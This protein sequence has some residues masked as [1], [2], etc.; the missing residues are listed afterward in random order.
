MPATSS[1]EDFGVSLTGSVTPSR[2]RRKDSARGLAA[3]ALKL[4][5]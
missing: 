1:R 2:L 5:G 4:T 3:A